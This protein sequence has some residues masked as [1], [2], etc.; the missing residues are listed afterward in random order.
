MGYKTYF[1]SSVEYFADGG[2]IVDLSTSALP[3]AFPTQTTSDMERVEAGHEILPDS[4]VSIV[5][6]SGLTIYMLNSNR[7][8]KLI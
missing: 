7:Q 3:V 6:D 4:T 5:D 2:V 8:W 1:C